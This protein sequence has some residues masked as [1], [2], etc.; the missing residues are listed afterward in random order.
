MQPDSALSVQLSRPFSRSFSTSFTAFSQ[1]FSRSFTTALSDL[2]G[3]LLNALSALLNALSA[4]SVFSTLR[5]NIDIW[6]ESSVTCNTSYAILQPF[7]GFFGV[8]A[9]IGAIHMMYIYTNISG[10]DRY[11]RSRGR[12]P[13]VPLPTPSPAARCV[14][15]QATGV[16]AT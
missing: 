14:S 10:L 13:P 11:D 1:G 16:P 5:N 15:L 8:A 12:R 2:Q 3:H 7:V 9:F 4:L 6:Y